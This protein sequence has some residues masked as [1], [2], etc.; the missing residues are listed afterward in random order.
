[1]LPQ[2]SQF[3]AALNF[4]S[5]FELHFRLSTDILPRGCADTLPGA[6]LEPVPTPVCVLPV[7]ARRCCCCCCRACS[8][9]CCI[10]LS[11]SVVVATG[12]GY[13]SASLQTALCSE[14]AAAEQH[15]VESSLGCHC[16][17][18]CSIATDTGA[19]AVA[20]IAVVSSLRGKPP[21]EISGGGPCPH[22][23]A[24]VSCTLCQQTLALTP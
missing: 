19:H 1:M 17:R 3:S 14:L 4:T 9:R 2:L 23:T 11:K 6:I 8:I 13:S 16:L 20:R 24:C 10:V 18:H 22:N 7:C 15:A 12:E 5:G 21:I